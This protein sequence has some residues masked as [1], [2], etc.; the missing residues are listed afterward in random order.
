MKIYTLI[1]GVNGVGKSS[2]TGL[3]RAER[4]DL[5]Q[6]VDPDAITARCGSD[7]YEGGKQAV[8]RIE[9]ALTGS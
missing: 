1:G 8:A 9:A 6:I 2:F 3:L 5:G 4:S 7:E